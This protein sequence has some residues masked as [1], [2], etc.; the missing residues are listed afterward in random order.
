MADDWQS[1]TGFVDPGSE[2]DDEAQAYDEDTG[3]RAS[4]LSVPASGWTD[5]IELTRAS[6]S[7]DKVRFWAHYYDGYIDTVD[8]DLYYSG[9]WHDLYEG[10]YTHDNWTEKAIGST[11]TV[12]AMR[13]RFYNDYSSAQNCRFYEA[14]FNQVGVPSGQ[15]YI[16]RVQHIAG[17]RTMGV[18]Q[19]G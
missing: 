17:M 12:T 4:R 18:N 14:D 6:L 8:I 1:P 15:P 13:L 2:W 10:A 16:S 19:V 11:Q 3:T 9:G 7:C 5:F